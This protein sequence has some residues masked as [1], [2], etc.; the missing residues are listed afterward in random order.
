MAVRGG[1]TYL[2]IRGQRELA[3]RQF[4]SEGVGQD[5]NLLV[6]F[7]NLTLQKQ[8]SVLLEG[9]LQ[10]GRRRQDPGQGNVAGEQEGQPGQ[11]LLSE[12]HGVD[13]DGISNAG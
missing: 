2:A 1:K 7:L 13:Q 8:L 6:R 4:E 11:D 12:L 9:T 3:C 10:P 5:E